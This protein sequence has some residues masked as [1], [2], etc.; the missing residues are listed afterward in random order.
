MADQD[1]EILIRTQSDLSGV[2]DAQQ[3]LKDLTGASQDAGAETGRLTGA[4]AKLREAIH[5]LTREFPG[6]AHAARLGLH[7]IGLAVGA[8]A[9]AFQKFKQAI[10]TTIANLQLDPY[11]SFEGVLKALDQQAKATT[12]AIRA[13]D[14]SLA[15][16]ST[17]AERA[18]QATELLIARM[19]SL[20]L[21]EA[22]RDDRKKAIAL[23]RI[24]AQEKEGLLTP[25]EALAAKDKVEEE[26]AERKVQRD[27]KLRS[28]E[29]QALA[30]QRRAIMEQ[31]TKLLPELQQAERDQAGLLPEAADQARLEQLTK[32]L[33][34]ARAD[35]AR[36][37][38]AGDSGFISEKAAMQAIESA[39][40][41]VATYETVLGDW[42]SGIKERQGQRLTAQERV[43]DLQR[44]LTSGKSQVE[45]IDQRLPGLV[46]QDTI[47][48]A[49]D[50]E[51]LGY[52]RQVRQAQFRAE[53]AIPP[54]T[55]RWAEQE[56]RAG[57]EAG[58]GQGT[59]KLD[60]VVQRLATNA[61]KETPQ[62]LQAVAAAIERMIGAVG[63]SAQELRQRVERV[64]QQLAN[65]R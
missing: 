29:I 49:A 38:H 14:T 61:E 2:K 37:K 12:E 65:N 59:S 10:D 46:Q 62:Q 18:A 55:R 23:A 32:N 58:A 4:K 26:F 22:A 9:F 13:W 50:R 53:T 20:A 30:N 1:L 24:D 21:V 36:A 41:R 48:S 17:G 15:Q 28:D 5:G 33:Q 64:E 44:Q 7:P 31:R 56:V 43:A 57:L 45:A 40:G 52:D 42:R 35:L 47:Q 11:A 39:E 19:K 27:A 6:L 16:G 60:D 63:V 54:A 25:Q 3:G 34:A 51:L 8:A